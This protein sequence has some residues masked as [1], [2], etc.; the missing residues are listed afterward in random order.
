MGPKNRPANE[1]KSYFCW[2]RKSWLFFLI[3]LFMN[4][5]NGTILLFSGSL[6]KI[7]CTKLDLLQDIRKFYG[8]LFDVHGFLKY[9][10]R[11]QSVAFNSLATQWVV[12]QFIFYFISWG[13]VKLF[14]RTGSLICG[15]MQREDFSEGQLISRCGPCQLSDWTQQ[16]QRGTD[17]IDYWSVT[18]SNFLFC[19]SALSWPYFSRTWWKTLTHQIWHELVHGDPRYD[20][21]NI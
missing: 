1:K 3:T 12:S 20:H 7:C 13:G 5:K 17:P 9:E 4:M 16:E 14:P 2:S 8:A 6:S 21:M 11:H 18:S 10:R 19:I 15:R